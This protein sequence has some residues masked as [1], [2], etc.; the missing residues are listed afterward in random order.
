MFIDMH[1]HILPNVD[2]GA[3]NLNM[4]IKMLQIAKSEGIDTI[5]T[6]P[7]YMTGIYNWTSQNAEDAFESLNKAIT[8]KSIN[9]KLIRGNEV[10]LDQSVV[11]QIKLNECRTIGNTSYVL[12]ELPIYEPPISLFSMIEDF[13]NSGYRPIIAHPER[14]QYL[15]RETVG[16]LIDLDCLL[17]INSGSITGFYGKKLYEA[18]KSLVVEGNVHFIGTDAHN[19]STYAPRLKKAYSIISNW[20]GE[21]RAEDLFINNPEKALDNIK[22]N[23]KQGDRTVIF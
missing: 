6:T 5:V 15:S 4:A 3:K 2:D 7:H 14:Y 9:I 13:F 19:D 16:K 8:D 12:I 21:E 10:Y 1:S 17:Q 22:I 20:I 18:A 23:S 11:Q